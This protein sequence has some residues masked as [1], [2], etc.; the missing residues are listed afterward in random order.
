[1]N[2]GD[3]VIWRDRRYRLRGFDP[4]SVVDR[5]AYLEDEETGERVVVPAWEP[6]P[7]LAGAGA[8]PAP[9]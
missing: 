8:D 1:M 3:L 5:C 9:G 7:E 6:A 4:M 2:L